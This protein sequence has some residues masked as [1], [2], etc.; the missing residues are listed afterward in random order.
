[1][2]RLLVMKLEIKS[3]CVL[4]LGSIF[5]TD[6]CQYGPSL[7]GRPQGHPQLY[8]R[9]SYPL[10]LRWQTSSRILETRSYSSQLASQHFNQL[11]IT[12]NVFYNL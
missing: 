3:K 6:P 9:V 2:L 5:H 10:N 1:M 11:G 8:T 7:C 4:I 12:I